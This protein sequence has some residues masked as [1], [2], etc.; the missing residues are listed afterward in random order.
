[1]FTFTVLIFAVFIAAIMT[2][3]SMIAD[4]SK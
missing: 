2:D 1:M 3:I 4:L